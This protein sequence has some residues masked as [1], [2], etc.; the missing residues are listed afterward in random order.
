M[1]PLKQRPD[2]NK[3]VLWNTHISL[4]CGRYLVSGQQ[5]TD[6]DTVV[7]LT[8]SFTHTNAKFPFKRKLL[9][10]RQKYNL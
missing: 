6:I 4:I 10:P 7:K 5:D 1:V 2:A 8:N 3:A 9:I